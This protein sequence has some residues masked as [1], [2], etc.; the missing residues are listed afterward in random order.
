MTT[1]ARIT[2]I[3]SANAFQTKTQSL[4]KLE[5]KWVRIHI[6]AT[7]PLARV[8]VWFALCQSLQSSIISGI[9]E[10]L[11]ST[12]SEYSDGG[13]SERSRLP[14]VISLSAAPECKNPAKL[15]KPK[16]KPLGHPNV[17]KHNT[18]VGAAS[19]IPSPL[20]LLV[21]RRNSLKN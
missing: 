19:R 5:P 16:R 15:P 9:P 18:A 13:T 8:G 6:S 4:A 20:G 14:E 12:L 3:R 21:W 2:G 10:D 7:V 11:S 1:A 17:K